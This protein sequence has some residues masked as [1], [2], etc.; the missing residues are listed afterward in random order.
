MDE[1]RL[2]FYIHKYHSTVYRLAY[3][4]LK[5]PEDAIEGK[6]KLSEEWIYKAA[7]REVIAINKFNVFLTKKDGST[8][9]AFVESGGYSKNKFTLNLRY[10]NRDLNELIENETPFDS[11]IA[12]DLS[13][14]KSI[15]IN[16]K[17][18]DMQ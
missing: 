9:Y 3:S 4:Y 6:A 7:G 2:S 1:S 14:I 17:T 10:I 13:E 8:V 15:T 5:N 18:F 11:Y 12:V 16:G